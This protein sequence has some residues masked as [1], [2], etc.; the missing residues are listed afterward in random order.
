MR[1]PKWYI[2]GC[3][4][5]Q[6]LRY[7]IRPK[8]ARFYCKLL[9]P[10]NSAMESQ[11]TEMKVPFWLGTITKQLLLKNFFE[12]LFTLSSVPFVYIYKHGGKT[13]CSSK[14]FWDHPKHKVISYVQAFIWTPKLSGNPENKVAAAEKQKFVYQKMQNFE[15]A[16]WWPSL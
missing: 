13:T 4:V 2:W 6:L 15:S 5:A 7:R 8:M 12:I 14:N 1:F 11:M 3:S 16:P 10:T 9:R